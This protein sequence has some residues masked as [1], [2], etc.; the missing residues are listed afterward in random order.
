MVGMLAAL[1]ILMF[2]PYIY[3][4]MIDNDECWFVIEPGKIATLLSKGKLYG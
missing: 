3:D 4:S 1:L 2:M